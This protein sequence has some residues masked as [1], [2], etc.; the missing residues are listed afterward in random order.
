MFRAFS[1][2]AKGNWHSKKSGTGCAS[3]VHGNNGI[4][5]EE[6]RPR[7]RRNV[8]TSNDSQ[9]LNDSGA[10]HAFAIRNSLDLFEAN[11]S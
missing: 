3:N 10:T 8:E 9:E 6:V 1:T 4:S 11:W 7:L 5:F 2:C